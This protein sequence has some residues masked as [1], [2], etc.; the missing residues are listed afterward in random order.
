MKKNLEFSEES[1]KVEADQNIQANYEMSEDNA[2]ETESQS[3]SLEKIKNILDRFKNSTVQE[4]T[5]E[6]V[7]RNSEFN[8][9][10]P[11]VI[12][13]KEVTLEDQKQACNLE[14]QEAFSFDE[15][16]GRPENAGNL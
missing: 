8:H 15:D 9:I 4:N 16:N 7:E 14:S 11:Q 12:I 3:K 6:M 2:H 13:E 10:N 1:D 5:K